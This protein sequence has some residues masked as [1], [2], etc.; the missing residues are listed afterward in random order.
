MTKAEV[1]EILPFAELDGLVG[2][3]TGYGIFV[4]WGSSRMNVGALLPI[5]NN[6]FLLNI[7]VIEGMQ[8][9]NYEVCEFSDCFDSFDAA[10]LAA[11]TFLDSKRRMPPEIRAA[12][13]QLT[14]VL[15][16]NNARNDYLT[17]VALDTHR[18]IS[19]SEGDIQFAKALQAEIDKICTRLGKTLEQ[20]RTQL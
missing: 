12:A 2:A 6:A 1:V 19:E 5:D 17:V 15:M 4:A 10:V 7:Q 20:L 9:S 8:I 11:Q 14:Q 18:R 3:S 13:E 16:S